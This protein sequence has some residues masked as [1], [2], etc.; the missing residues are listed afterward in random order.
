[1]DSSIRVAAQNV[2]DMSQYYANCR[3][4][5][6]F[7]LDI[8]DAMRGETDIIGDRHAARFWAGIG[9]AIRA[10]AVSNLLE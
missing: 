6:T 8:L 5:V 1:M 4:N 2:G 7:V 9:D 3:D 10:F